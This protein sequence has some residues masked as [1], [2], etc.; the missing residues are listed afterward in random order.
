M[1]VQ[2]LIGSVCLLVATINPSLFVNDFSGLVILQ[3]QQLR[4]RAQVKVLPKYPVEVLKDRRSGIVVMQVRFDASGVVTETR[5]I[6][7][8]DKRFILPTASALKQWRFKPILTSTG[9]LAEGTGKVTFYFFWKKGHG[10]CEDPL[11]FSKK[12]TA[13]VLI[14][15]ENT[16]KAG[17]V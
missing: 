2:T 6:E 4:E 14:Q 13:W 7:A 12:S 11:I 5:T 10:W 17:S 3:E 15:F 1:K 16:P 9:K 8:V